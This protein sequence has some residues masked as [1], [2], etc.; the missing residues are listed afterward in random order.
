MPS[1][2]NSEHLNSNNSPFRFNAKEL[3]QATGNYY[4]GAR[5]YNPKWSTW[6]SVDPL[7]EETPDKTPYHFTSNN[8]INRVDPDGLSDYKKDKDGN[9][10]L[11]EETT[12]DTDVLFDSEGVR[13]GE[14]N[15]GYLSD[16]INIE[17]N[18]ILLDVENKEDFHFYMKF[19]ID[20]SVAE[21]KEIGGFILDSDKGFDDMYIS[22]YKESEPH[23]AKG[24]ENFIK[25]DS[26]SF[27]N[28]EL[29]LGANKYKANS[30]FHTQ[31]DIMSV[32]YGT[33]KPSTG[34]IKLT[35]RLKMPGLILGGWGGIGLIKTDGTYKR[36]GD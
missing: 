12:D 1:F 27:K 11:V 6:L 33:S 14:V 22:S 21:N 5:Y 7:A 4:Y 30:W 3:D 25:S 16:G 32:G 29:N 35:K 18:G 36:W 26:Y 17:E 20:L 13:I 2:S 19:T 8:P 15:K 9:I 24:L 31:P 10:T 28:K 23:K 34:D